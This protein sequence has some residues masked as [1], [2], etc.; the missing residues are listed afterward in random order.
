MS[1]SSRW[2]EFLLHAYPRQ[3]REERG[4]ELLA[5]IFESVASGTWSSKCLESIAIVGHGFQMRLGLLAHQFGGRTLA[6]ASMPA[7]ASILHA[8]T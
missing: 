3:Y 1:G 2:F 5:T 6:L 4:E 8:T 7:L